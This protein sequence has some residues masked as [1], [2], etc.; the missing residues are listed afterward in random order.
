MAMSNKKRPYHIFS[1]PQE[2]EDIIFAYAYDGSDQKKVIVPRKEGADLRHLRAAS[3]PQVNHQQVA[4]AAR[5]WVESHQIS[6]SGV[7][8]GIIDRDILSGSH[9]VLHAFAT[10]VKATLWDVHEEEN[11]EEKYPRLRKLTVAVDPSYLGGVFRREQVRR[12]KKEIPSDLTDDDI[13]ASDAYRRLM[14]LKKVYH[15]TVVSTRPDLRP[16]ELLATSLQRLERVVRDDLKHRP[17]KGSTD[18]T[19]IS[20]AMPLYLGSEVPCEIQ[21]I[22][23]WRIKAR[24]I[25]VRLIACL[26]VLSMLWA[27]GGFAS[28]WSGFD[29]EGYRP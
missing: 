26:A 18:S 6:T 7:A 15:L 4:P 2:L 17:K 3:L 13:R 12:F 27:C 23:L 22:E 1:L 29:V 11:F 16:S 28:C 9:G 10:D 8:P 19:P 24:R 25:L 5:A 20:T 21:W 14:A